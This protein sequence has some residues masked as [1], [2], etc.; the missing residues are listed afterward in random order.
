V[1]YWESWEVIMYHGNW[2]V[3]VISRSRD[4]MVDYDAIPLE[5]SWSVHQF[6]I[7]G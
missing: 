7:I 4:D 5:I 6:K 3:E 1:G 2:E